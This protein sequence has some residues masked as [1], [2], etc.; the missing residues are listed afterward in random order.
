MEEEKKESKILLCMCRMSGHEMGY[1]EDAFREEWVVPLGPNVNGFEQDLE[2]FLESRPHGSDRNPG[3]KYDTHPEKLKVVA[4]SAGTAALHLSLIEAGVKAGD[5]VMVQSFTFSASA[6]PVAYLGATPVFVDSEPATWNMDPALLDEAIADRVAKTGRKPAAIVTVD[7]Y[8]MPARLDAIEEVASRWGIPLIEDAAEA[9]GSRFRGRCCG[10]FGRYGILSFNGNKIITTSGGGALVCHSAEEARHA[11]YLATQ[12]RKGYAYYQHEEIGYNYRLSNIS[13]GIGRGQMRV[14]EDYIAHHRHRME[15]YRR[16]LGP[17]EGIRLHDNPSEE[18]DSN[19]WLC[20][21]TLDEDVRVIGRENAYAE[22]IEGTIGG[23]GGV[24]GGVTATETDCQPDAD[25]EALRL[26]L[27]ERNIESRPLWKPMH[28]QPV[29]ASAPSYVN[30]VSERLFRRGLCL[31][32][33][34]WVGDEEADR[35]I[36][37]IRESIQKEGQ[38]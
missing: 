35:V 6:N 13:A 5:E 7:L 2:N 28:R 18:F 36:S 11:L 29:F 12:A 27:A 25:I 14:L 26:R 10:T 31:P 19:F 16:H 17:V 3:E 34:P 33:G 38:G 32:A 4:L 9:F 23:A 20:T 15:Y 37:V 30:G 22:K 8:G 21:M 1:I 24:T